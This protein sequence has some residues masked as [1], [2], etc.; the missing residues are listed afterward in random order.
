LTDA[1]DVACS[2]FAHTY[3]V[4]VKNLPDGLSAKAFTRQQLDRL[5]LGQKL[6]AIPWGSKKVILPPSTLTPQQQK[7]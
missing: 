1:R 6:E 2:F 4:G 5:G 3:K 7:K